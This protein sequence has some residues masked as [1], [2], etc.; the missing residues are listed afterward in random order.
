[1]RVDVVVVAVAVVVVV[2]VSLKQDINLHWPRPNVWARP[3]GGNSEDGRDSGGG[4]ICGG[5]GG[6]IET[7]HQPPLASAQCPGAPV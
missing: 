4:G 3:P 6:I 7:R 5:C 2:L 1:M